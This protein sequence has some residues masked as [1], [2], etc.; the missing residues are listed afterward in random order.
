MP[1]PAP[2]V[3]SP[4]TLAT[5]RLAE[6]TYGRDAEAFTIVRRDSTLSLRRDRGGHWARLRSLGGDS[7]IADDALE[8]GTR[9]MHLQGDGVLRIG[10]ES[11]RRQPKSPVPA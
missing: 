6:G 7:L 4:T 9:V 8:Y 5:A 3:T 11:F 1:L 10:S 2:V